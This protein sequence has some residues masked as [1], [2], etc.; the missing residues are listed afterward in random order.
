MVLMT[1]LRAYMHFHGTTTTTPALVYD[2][3][4]AGITIG[5]DALYAYTGDSSLLAQCKGTPEPLFVPG[6][7]GAYLN[8][9]ADPTTFLADPAKEAR[10]Y[11]VDLNELAYRI[12]YCGYAPV[13]CRGFLSYRD[14]VKC[15]IEDDGAP[16]SYSSSKSGFGF[17][18][19]NDLFLTFFIQIDAST[20]ACGGSESE[21]VIR[22]VP[23]GIKSDSSVNTSHWIDVENM[24]RFLSTWNPVS[25]YLSAAVRDSAAKILAERH[26][27]IDSRFMPFTVEAEWE[28]FSE[29]WMKDVYRVYKT[30]NKAS[31]RLSRNSEVWSALVSFCLEVESC[32]QQ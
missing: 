17:D 1:K 22:K 25:D 18:L 19:Y 6:Q 8:D 7:C 3:L 28:Y 32:G 15:V 2:N 27:W 20:L 9:L 4:L 12:S 26:L 16:G 14:Y 24:Q 30:I 21:L 5:V 11:T 31:H 23:D 13:E 10:L 29:P